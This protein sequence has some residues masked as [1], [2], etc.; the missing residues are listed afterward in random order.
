MCPRAFTA[1]TNVYSLVTSLMRNKDA[2]NAF[3]SVSCMLI[4]KRI[5]TYFTWNLRYINSLSSLSSSSVRA[6][7]LKVKFA[8]LRS[9]RVYSESYREPQICY[10]YNTNEIKLLSYTTC[11][12]RKCPCSSASTA[13]LP[14]SLFTSTL[15][16]SS[17]R[18][19]LNWDGIPWLCS[20][21]RQ[22]D[23]LCFQLRRIMEMSHN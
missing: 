15:S 3:G 18:L 7:Y 5:W 13:S 9:K 2:F 23:C 8:F 4:V 11:Y 21:D 10:F 22:Q 1:D 14:P 17:H 16:T 19:S 20:E 12:L 6:H